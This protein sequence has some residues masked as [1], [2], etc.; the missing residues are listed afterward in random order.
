MQIMHPRFLILLISLV[1][2]NGITCGQTTGLVLSGGGAKGIAHIGV[3]K[4]L[5]ENNVRIDY[6]AGTSIGA[7]VGSLYAM[8]YSPEEMMELFK[9]DDFARW[10][11]GEIEARYRFSYK[12][13][14]DNPALITI[15][16]IND[17]DE[18]KPQIP[19]YLIPS[20]VMDFAFMEL[21]AGANA[22]CERDFNKLMIPFR[23]VAA[24]IYNKKPLIWRKGNLSHAVRSSMTYPLYFEPIMVDSILLFDGGI[25]NNF[26]FDIL[27]DDF[28]PDFIIGSKVVNTSKRPDRDDL[29]LQIENMVMQTTNFDIPDSLGIIVES[30]FPDVNLLDF[31]K[32]DSLYRAGYESAMKAMPGILERASF[33]SSEELINRR[34]DFINEMP[35]LTFSN[36]KINGVNDEQEQY[37]K[38]LL[39]RQDEVITIDRLK[40]KYFRLVTEENIR[41]AYP[42]A[43]YNR[44]SGSYELILDINLKSAYNLSAGGL[45]SFTS[46][47]QGFLEFNYYRLSDIFNRFT[48]NMYLGRYYTSFR[49]A[50]RVAIPKKEILFLDLSITENRWNYYSNDI[51]SLFDAYFPSYI[52][53]REASFEAAAGRPVNN[54]STIRGRLLFGW[55]RHNYYQDR[56]LVEAGTPDNTQYLNG[57]F[58]IQLESSRLNRRQFP[59]AGN[60]TTLS[61]SINAGYEYFESGSTDTINIVENEGLGHS[62]YK[63]NFKSEKYFNFSDR[64]TLGTLAELNISNKEYSSNYT[65]TQINSYSFRPTVFSNLIYAESLRS[66]SFL[67]AGLRPIL[68]INNDFSIRSGAYLFIP[69]FPVYEEGDDVVRGDFFGDYRGVAE[70]AAIYHTSVGPISIG[71][72]VFS[73]ERR[74]V[75]YYLNFGYILF[76]KSGLD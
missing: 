32:A 17:N 14:K 49:L 6:I 75:Y 3:I 59:T 74:K 67:G 24:D 16:I 38:N 56:V 53:R 73:H 54:Y 15:P 20:Q 5:E 11:T 37:I 69:F 65:A 4:A 41:N 63:L 70:L 29:M 76:N 52:Q 48:G 8:G 44:E 33:I 26:P 62:W 55:L 13:N 39:S 27:L 10:K 51:T 60:Y 47:N 18:T 64:L 22:A 61:A 43:F 1:C 45:L 30:K 35:E 40:E 2:F 36:I 42:E 12:E 7:I 34:K 21:T 9:S 57:S 66:D 72:N 23:C 71:A 46:Y 25:Y 19:S 28:S 58:K 50:H 31:E 68:T